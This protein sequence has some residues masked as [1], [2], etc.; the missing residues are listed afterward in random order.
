MS[1]SINDDF[2]FLV[3]MLP[4]LFDDDHGAVI[5]IPNSLSR[6]FS[7]ARVMRMVQLLARQHD[8]PHRGC[9]FVE[10]D[11]IDAGQLCAT[12]FRL[13]SLLMTPGV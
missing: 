2:H 8:R 5:K 10:V 9:K 7:E 3:E 11:D 13:K 6:L 4:A 1:F 12:V